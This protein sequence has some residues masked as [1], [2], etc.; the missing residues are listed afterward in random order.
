[1]EKKNCVRRCEPG[2]QAGSCEY[3]QASLIRKWLIS[4]STINAF[5]LALITV[6]STIIAIL[7][8]TILRFMIT[9]G[10]FRRALAPKIDRWIQDGVFQLQRKVYESQGEGTWQHIDK[11][12]PVT[13]DSERLKDLSDT[14]VAQENQATHECFHCSARKLQSMKSWSTD[15]TVVY[16]KVGSMKD[17]EITPG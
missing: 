13:S 12:V 3:H 6:F 4:C 8:F 17:G 9:L 7:D 1:M 15:R 10:R 2:S 5:G 11:E 14:S 16:D